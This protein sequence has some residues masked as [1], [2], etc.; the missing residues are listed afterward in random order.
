M[1]VRFWCLVFGLFILGVNLLFA[2]GWFTGFGLV[3]FSWFV[4]LW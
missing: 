2:S 4:C 1:D 3:C